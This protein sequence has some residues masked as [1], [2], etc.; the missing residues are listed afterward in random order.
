M[1]NIYLTNLG[2][3]NEGYLIGEWVELPIDEADLT[4]VLKR[5]GI[6]EHYEETFITDYETDIDG[7]KVSE[8]DSIDYLNRIA[9]L[10]EDDP[11]KVAGL[12]YFGYND[13][14]EIADHISDICYCCTPEGSETEDYAL[15]YY[16]AHELECIKIPEELENYFDY[17]AYG[18]DISLSGRF[19]TAESGAI[20]ECIA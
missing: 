12:M 7:L 4:E 1:L 13:P 20:Y 2:K 16:F 6:D 15:G 5:I 11:E 3:Y 8:Y 9:A 17:D 19:Y 18:R 14:E 10:A